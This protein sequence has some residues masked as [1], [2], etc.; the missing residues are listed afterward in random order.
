MASELFYL[1]KISTSS[2]I[3]NF[4]LFYGIALGMTVAIFYISFKYLESPFLK[5]QKVLIN[6][7]L[8][9]EHYVYK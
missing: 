3:Y 7:I 5:I 1:F 4:I 8:A 6:K 2:V 9:P